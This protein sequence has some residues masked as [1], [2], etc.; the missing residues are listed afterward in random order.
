MSNSPLPAARSEGL[1]SGTPNSC[2]NV[3]ENKRV[4]CCKFVLEISKVA[5]CLFKIR[6]L[7]EFK[8]TAP[9]FFCYILINIYQLTQAKVAGGEP[10][11]LVTS[12][13]FHAHIKK[14]YPNRKSMWVDVLK[15]IHS[16]Q[17]EGE[18]NFIFQR[19]V[20]V[21]SSPNFLR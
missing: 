5:N 16:K 9:L 18:H 21:S 7:L 10:L 19:C 8:S 11:L 6:H 15:C 1:A 12:Q 4:P 14:E 2:R 13:E 17:N 3:E 20:T